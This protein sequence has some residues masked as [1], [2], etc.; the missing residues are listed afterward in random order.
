M[1]SFRVAGGLALS[2]TWEPQGAKNE[3]AM[4]L[5]APLLTSDEVVVSNCPMTKDIKTMLDLLN[6]LGVDIGK[7]ANQELVLRCAKIQ[8]RFLDTDDYHSLFSSIRGSVNLIGV[9]LTRLGYAIMPIPGGD[10]IGARKLDTLIN[11]FRSLGVD[12]QYHSTKGFFKLRVREEYASR[13]HS[14]VLDEASVT[15]TAAMV[16]FASGQ[17]TVTEIFHAACEPY[18]V[19]LCSLLGRM[20]AVIEGIGSNLLTIHG[21]SEL[22][23]GS[24]R[25]APDIIEIGSMFAVAATTKSEFLIKCPPMPLGTIRVGFDRLG[26]TSQWIDDGLVVD[27]TSEQRIRRSEDG[28]MLTLAD[29][30]WPGFP[31]DLLPLALISAVNAEGNVMFHQ[32]MYEARLVFANQLRSIGADIT[33]CD[34]HRAIVFGLGPDNRLRGS[35]LRAGDIR[36]GMALLAAALGGVGTSVVEGGEQLDRGYECLESRLQNLGADVERV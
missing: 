13:S 23:G 26:I 16:L 33:I 32:K 3:A 1:S 9:L 21:V 24:H 18:I 29:S 20:G 5:C 6:G 22:A 34:P 15:G 7:N 19:R 28:S 11:G 10:R 8:G 30:I 25:L 17:N 36:S 14:I 27:G 31:T 4:T 12:V 2:G 35:R